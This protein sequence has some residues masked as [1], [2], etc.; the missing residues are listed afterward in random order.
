[1]IKDRHFHQFFIRVLS[2]CNRFSLP[3][4]YSLFGL[5]RGV[6]I[7][8]LIGAQKLKELSCHLLN[9]PPLD[10]PTGLFMQFALLAD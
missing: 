5:G 1:M 9:Y 3:I 4:H 6:I 7:K 8:S 2:S 10:V